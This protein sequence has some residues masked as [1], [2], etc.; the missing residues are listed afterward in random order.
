MSWVDEIG[1][2][3]SPGLGSV[4]SG[5]LGFL[6]Q[7]DTNATSASNAQAANAFNA[8][9][10]QINRDYQTEMSNTAYQRQVKD[11]E[12]A[13]LNP[14]LAYIK[15]G[16]ASSP[17][18]STATATVPN[19]VSP[20]QGAAQFRLSSAQARATEATVPKITEE[21]RKIGSEISNIDADTVNKAASL[22]LIHEQTQ[23]TH[24]S[25]SEK[26]SLIRQ[27]DEQANK[28]AEEIKN[29][30]YEGQRLIA[31]AKNLDASSALIRTNIGVSISQAKLND[32]LSV[33]ALQESNLL[34]AENSAIDEAG[35]FGKEFGQ[36]KGA[37]DTVL[38]GINSVA[39]AIRGNNRS[40]TYRH[41]YG[42]K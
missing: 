19:Y 32:M 37:I 28:I 8:Q 18:G 41:T 38:N 16:G 11:M 23:L 22:Y 31:L 12:A 3:I 24:L 7:L 25:I 5:G 4:I 35:N 40:V 30:P 1:N 6:G 13:G 21:T 36:Y 17:V 20:I 33:K 10:A 14:M 42:N 29:I 2:A 34:K 9:Q 26:Q 27:I 39:Q 15:G